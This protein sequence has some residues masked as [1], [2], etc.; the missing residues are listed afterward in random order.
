[1]AKKVIVKKF[2]KKAK[3]RLFIAFL[4]FGAVISM[5]S[6]KFL[7]NIKQIQ[8][9]KDEEKYLKEQ[10]VILEE[11]E[12]IL[13]SDIQKLKDPSYIAKYVRE[14]YLYSKDGELIIRLPDNLK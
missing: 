5:L 14:K 8:E 4:L 6:Y 12:K 2:G 13:E 9:M 7:Y 3:G 11:E 1:L 10:L